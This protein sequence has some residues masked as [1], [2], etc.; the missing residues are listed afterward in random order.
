[1]T[2]SRMVLRSLIPSRFFLIIGGLL[3]MIQAAVTAAA[4]KA[5]GQWVDHPTKYG[6]WWVLGFEVSRIALAAVQQLLFSYSGSIVSIGLRSRTWSDLLQTRDQVIRPIPKGRIA[7]RVLSDTQSVQEMIAGG[8]IG[9]FGNIF[10]ITWLW[11]GMATI[12]AKITLAAFLPFSLFLFSL[13]LL[14]KRLRFNYHRS[15]RRITRLHGFFAERMRSFDLLSRAR[16]NA[17]QLDRYAIQNDQYTE[18]QLGVANTFALLH[19]AATIA[20]GACATC[21]IL[22]SSSA[23]ITTG[24]MI[25]LLTSSFLLHQPCVE[26][27]DRMNLIIAGITGYERLFE[28]QNYSKIDKSPLVSP[29]GPPLVFPNAHKLS[30]FDRGAVFV[31]KDIVFRYGPLDQKGPYVL[32]GHSGEMRR[33]EL[34]CVFGPSG[35]GK[36]TLIKLIAGFEEAESGVFLLIKNDQVVYELKSVDRMK[37]VQWVSQESQWLIGGLLENFGLQSNEDWVL[38]L[39]NISDFIKGLPEAERLLARMKKNPARSP[40]SFSFAERQWIALF[41]GV[42]NDRPIWVLDEPTASMNEAMELEFEEVLQRLARDHWVMLVSH[43]PLHRLSG[44]RLLDASYLKGD[45]VSARGSGSSEYQ[46]NT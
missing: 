20:V 25:S 30:Q 13:H 2:L 42:Q 36:S 22:L 24:E 28:L 45:S 11:I 16:K 39:A 46:I 15:K 33:G 12:N 37:W 4:P 5:L 38:C 32:H 19:P 3:L 1:M 7:S 35:S 43:R 21:V 27:C 6:L 29:K 41:R 31:W 14:R 9:V 18:A 10:L 40:E 23:G 34:L 44:A 8:V 17:E 26:F